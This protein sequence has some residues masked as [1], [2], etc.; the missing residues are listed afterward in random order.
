MS[1]V[2]EGPDDG[3]DRSWHNLLWSSS[4]FLLSSGNMG[5]AS[6]AGLDEALARPWHAFRLPHGM[7]WCR[8]SVERML[9]DMSSSRHGS[10]APAVGRVVVVGEGEGLSSFVSGLAETRPQRALQASP[11]PPPDGHSTSIYWPLGPPMPFVA[12]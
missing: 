5:W 3:D 7:G 6:P 2:Q 10:A 8:V 4:L 9:Q 12:P 11:Y 1:Q